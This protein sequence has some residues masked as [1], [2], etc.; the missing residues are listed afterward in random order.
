MKRGDTGSILQ[1]SARFGRWSGH[2]FSHGLRRLKA[3]HTQFYTKSFYEEMRNGSRR[4][5]EVIVPLV[6]QL[7]TVRSVVDVGCGDG[8]WLAIFQKYGVDDILGVDGDYVTGDVL[9][10]SQDRFQAVDL[11]RPFS[12]G[13]VFDLAI[14]LE[15][16]E[17]LPADCG[18]TFVKSLTCLAP[19]VLFS[20]AI[21]RQGGDHHTNEQ[22]PDYWAKLFHEHGFLTV[23]FIRKRIWQDD[24]VDSWYAQNTL[25]FVQANL[26]E[27]NALLKV[28][29]ERTNP[30]QLSL[31]HPRQYAY[32][33]SLYREAAFRADNPPPPSGLRE[34]SLLFLVCLRNAIRWR[35]Y[36]HGDKELH[37]TGEPK[38]RK[39][40]T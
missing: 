4:S 2:E 17:H 1:P 23:D 37:A 8:N 14:S 33:H 10:I 31:V 5:A 18:P 6:L 26:L 35:L 20:A 9:Q 15:V 12:L 22:W 39:P 25:L 7:L 19:V 24:S 40:I 29:F 28:E 36:P 34:A 38:S 32:V 3:M 11:S 16:A 21:P 27:N 13:R 30:R